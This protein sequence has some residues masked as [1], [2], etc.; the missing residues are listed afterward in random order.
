[1]SL[2]FQYILIQRR[3]TC[4]WKDTQC[5][6]WNQITTMSYNINICS[7]YYIKKTSIGADV[8]KLGPLYNV[9]GY[10]QLWNFYEK[11]YA[12]SSKITYRTTI[13]WSFNSPLGIYPK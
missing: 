10:V 3:Y 4:L 2:R 13:I 7:V 11:Q 8:E 12:V 1:M 6:Q 9:G 5:H